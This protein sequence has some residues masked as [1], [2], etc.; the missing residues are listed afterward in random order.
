MMYDS[1]K[2]LH[3]FKRIAEHATV[4]LGHSPNTHY[5][6]TKLFAH[7]L[8]TLEHNTNDELMALVRELFEE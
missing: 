1:T 6:K 4:V 3:T 2:Q 7:Y 5:L 8:S